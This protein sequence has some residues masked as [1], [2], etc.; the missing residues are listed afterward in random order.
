MDGVFG[1]GKWLQHSPK[2]CREQD[3]VMQIAEGPSHRAYERK[4]MVAKEVCDCEVKSGDF[5]PSSSPELNPAENAQG[6]LRLLV[7]EKV[8]AGEVR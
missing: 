7:A 8:K 3:G 6:Y 2:I 1:V 4:R 5:V